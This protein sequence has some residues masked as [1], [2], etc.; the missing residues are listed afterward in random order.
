[1]LKHDLNIIIFLINNDGYTI[2]RWVHGMTESCNDIPGWRY[3][4]LPDTMG[5]TRQNATAYRV[6]TLEQSEKLWGMPEFEAGW[7]MRFVEMAMPKEDAPLTLKMV[8]SAAAKT[9]AQ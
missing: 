9:N 6:G 8:C 1:M 3:A 4:Q 5:A 7:G 2:E